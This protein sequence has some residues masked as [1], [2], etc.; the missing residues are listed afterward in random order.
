[1]AASATAPDSASAV[2]G[3]DSEVQRGPE[4]EA[5]GAGFVHIGRVAAYIQIQPAV[6]KTESDRREADIVVE[7]RRPVGVEALAQPD[8]RQ[9]HAL[10]KCIRQFEID[11]AGRY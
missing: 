1:M 6:R 11:H 10:N 9:V 8:A 3:R 5:E 4:S 2:H 7:S